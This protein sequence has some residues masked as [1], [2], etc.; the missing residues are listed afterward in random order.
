MSAGKVFAANDHTGDLMA[1]APIERRV[2]WWVRGPVLAL[3]ALIIAMVS[4]RFWKVSPVA[5]IDAGLLALLAFAVVLILSEAFDT[6]SIG[7]LLSIS[8]EVQR[9]ERE[10]EKLEEQKASLLSQLVTV[11]ANQWQRQSSTTVLGDY[12]AAG[13]V[14]QATAEEAE[15]SRQS[16]SVAPT[17]AE[18]GPNASERARPTLNF[19]AIDEF[20]MD[21]YCLLRGVDKSTIIQDAKLVSHFH[22]IDGIS[23]NSMIFDG[24]INSPEGEAFIEVR[25][26]SA[27]SPMFRDRLY[28][29][30]SK[31]R[32]YGV[33]N[34]KTV[35][36]ELVL[37]GIPSR[38]GRPN[39]FD[40]VLNE[41]QPAISSKLLNVITVELNERQEA[42]MTR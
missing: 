35:R 37:V 27:V 23:N 10:V 7:K 42:E 5:Q 25:P 15:A 26:K 9:K 2:T 38:Q 28:M 1:S 6:F 36:L 33:K 39:D 3:A 21:R 22:D 4:Y 30:L 32:H 20:G 24:Y 41:F 13:R 18:E 16:D 17:A 34:G 29:M 19:R 14:E 11:S 40:R 12:H 31:I 8:R